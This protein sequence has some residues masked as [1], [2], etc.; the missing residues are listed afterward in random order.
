MYIYI[1]GRKTNISKKNW[2][3]FIPTYT[4]KYTKEMDEEGLKVIKWSMLDSPDKLG[5]GKMFME[6]EPVIILD[7]V[8]FR[9]R[10]KGAILLG[11]TSSD[12]ANKIG[13]PENSEHRTGKAIKFRCINPSHRFRLVRG[14][15]QYGVE[16]IKLYDNSIYFDTE[17]YLH[18]SE[19]SFRH[20]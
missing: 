8:F 4:D 20:F 15:I 14:L 9:E 3:S 2:N 11:Y 16:R 17:N 10:L 5:S 6:T 19:L 7:T 18:K 1:V 13:V 12:Y